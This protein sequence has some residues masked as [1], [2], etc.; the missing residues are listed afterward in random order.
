M[1]GKN[2]KGK[3]GTGKNGTDENG[4][5]KNCSKLHLE[6]LLKNFFN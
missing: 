1:H 5:G 4:T 3:N 2:G 6:N